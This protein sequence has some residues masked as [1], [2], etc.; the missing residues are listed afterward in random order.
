MLAVGFGAEFVVTAS[1]ILDERVTA[2]H[3]RRGPISQQAAHR[4]ESCFEAAVVPLDPAIRVLLGVMGGWSA[5]MT[6]FRAPAGKRF[7]L[8]VAGTIHPTALTAG[9]PSRQRNGA[10]EVSR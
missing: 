6:G 2:D 4:P 10:P 8:D 5:A 3:Y 9:T 1:K 7:G